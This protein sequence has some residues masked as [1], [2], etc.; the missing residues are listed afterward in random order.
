[1]GGDYGEGGMTDNEKMLE[2]FDGWLD[3]LIDQFE[4]ATHSGSDPLWMRANHLK[5]QAWNL[6]GRNQKM[7]LLYGKLKEA[8]RLLEGQS[9]HRS[10]FLRELRRIQNS[11]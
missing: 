1:M 11:N 5:K 6:R 7:K 4:Q 2:R 10:K 8:L 9:A 3:A